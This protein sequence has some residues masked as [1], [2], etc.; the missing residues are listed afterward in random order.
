MRKLHTLAKFCMLETFEP[1]Y[2]GNAS[3]HAKAG[4]E[5][6]KEV[7]DLYPG[8]YKEIFTESE[9]TKRFLDCHIVISAL[10]LA[11]L[12][13]VDPE[14]ILKTLKTIQINRV[15]LFF[16]NALK[17]ENIIGSKLSKAFIRGLFYEFLER[18]EQERGK[19][20][21]AFF[22]VKYR[23]KLQ[24][25]FAAF[26]I[27]KER[28]SVFWR[29]ALGIIFANKY[30]DKLFSM[31][32]FREMQTLRRKDM[33][34][35]GDIKKVPFS[36]LIG[37]IWKYLRA[38]GK[39]PEEIKE[40]LMSRTDLMSNTEV[41]R[42]LKQLQDAGKLGTKEQ[43]VKIEK[44]VKKAP[45]DVFSLLNMLFVSEDEMA[46]IT[47]NAIETKVN[48][49]SEELKKL[50]KDKKLGIAADVS[51]N[52]VGAERQI[53][54]RKIVMRRTFD[55]NILTAWFLSRISKKSEF[56]LFNEYIQYVDIAFMDLK[57]LLKE[58]INFKPDGGSAPYIALNDIMILEKGEMD[59]I[60]MISDFNENVP[61]RGL[62]AMKLPELARKFNKPIFLLQTEL[63][64]TE[65]TSLEKVIFDE[66][67]DNVYLIP[68]KRL[69]HLKQVLETIELDDEIKA[70]IIQI[71]T[72]R[73]DVEV[74]A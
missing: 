27:K 26:R 73:S 31:R 45:S 52:T 58:I 60:I 10:F 15:F 48:K 29:E 47:V 61:I 13:N 3:D 1:D 30:K 9:L 53:G 11:N 55:K 63:D 22:T 72:K 5:K 7:Y 64:I 39:S 69:E 21:A 6:H 74:F 70:L 57:T 25:L 4:L 32:V 18:L 24:A 62:F 8:Y 23:S 12:P 65:I 28:L 41:K 51:G 35:F 54:N 67:L 44:R 34:S 17:S 16:T 46:N 19:D 56:L 37:Y 49:L 38:D 68:I 36:V 33:L 66:K 59:A 43:R 20:Y 42:S 2:Y 40:Y 71:M 14:F 50:F